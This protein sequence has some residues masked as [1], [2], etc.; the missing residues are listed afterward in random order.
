M[1]NSFG[2]AWRQ[3]S[4]NRVKLAVA[5]AGVVVAVMLMLVQLGIRQGALDSSVALTRRITA[6]LVVASPRTKT[7]FQ[8]SPFPRR[9][10]RRMTADP[11]VADVVETYIAQARFRNPW[12]HVEFPITVY[13]L[14]TRRPMIELPGI[15][16]YLDALDLADHVVFDGLS[17]QTYG[18]VVAHLHEVGSVVTEVNYRRV[19]VVG[20]IEVGVSFNTDGNLYMSQANFLRLLPE[21]N[22]G[23]IDLGLVRLKA[24][25]DADV[26]RKRIAPLL[27][28]EATIHTRDELI[29]SEVRYMR[30]TA[31]LD[32]IFGLGAAIGFFIGFVVVYQILYTE[33]VN[34]LPHYAT[35]K[36][37][38]FADSYLFK[39]VLSQAAVLSV[40]GYVPGFLLA[41][42]VYRVATV[43]IQMQ[44]SM[45]WQRA[46][47]VF[48]LTL[49]MCGLSG[50]IALRKARTADPA[51]VF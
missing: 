14:V 10:L 46:V 9:L 32:F 6:D 26:V 47:G 45:T 33:V 12:D 22:P 41:L 50:A 36:A 4:H 13:G 35:L 3:L 7:I 31:P 37:V 42:G 28:H 16:R 49:L 1:L 48:A 25:R 19:D 30:E 43:A 44:F 15:D 34:H 21:R 27:G 29:A 2:V 40:L 23:A 8:P 51:D 39:L 20:M 38:G 5:C 11:D 17:R 24:G 18:P